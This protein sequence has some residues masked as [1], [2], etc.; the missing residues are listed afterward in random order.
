[1]RSKKQAERAGASLTVEYRPVAELIPYARNARTHSEEQVAQ[2]VGQH[3]RI[4][5][6]ESGPDRR[7]R[8][9]RGGTRPRSGRGEARDGT[10]SVHHARLVE[11]SS[12]ARLRDRG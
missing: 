8:R 11:R 2:I 6:H 10:G 12:E 5:L 7:R 3:Q 1:M 9:D 4:R